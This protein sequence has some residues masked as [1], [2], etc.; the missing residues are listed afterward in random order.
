MIGGI[1]DWLQW[2]SVQSSQGA[3]SRRLPGG[4]S[5]LELTLVLVVLA[6]GAGA[7]APRIAGVADAGLNVQ[8]DRLRRDISRV[9]L[10]ASSQ[11]MRLRIVS[12]GSSYAIS[13]IAPVSCAGNV[14]VDPETGEP[15]VIIL[16]R[17]VLFSSNGVL[18]FDGLG[19]PVDD[20]ALVAATTSIAL[21]RGSHAAKVEV[22]PLTGLARVVMQ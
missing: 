1:S 16:E 4:Y 10:M 19:R 8:A 14:M 18:D 6:L 5:L 22:L 2:M 13:C 17:D 12:A 11:G 21:T 7:V 15:F 3:R 20:A 9:Q